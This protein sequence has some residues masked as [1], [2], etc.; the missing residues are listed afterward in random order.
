M[1]NTVITLIVLVALTALG[2]LVY[3]KSN[4]IFPKTATP[5]QSAT[6]AEV[7]ELIKLYQLDEKVSSAYDRFMDYLKKIPSH[8]DETYF[9]KKTAATWAIDFSKTQKVAIT[10]AAVSKIKNDLIQEFN[11]AEVLA[12]IQ[13]K[14][15]AQADFSKAPSAEQKWDA[16]LKSKEL[17]DAMEI[18][19]ERMS[20]SYQYYL[21]EVRKKYGIKDGSFVV[22]K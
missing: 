21:D 9:V 19:R 22:P 16:Y 10:D 7:S 14:K 12:L 11:S 1:K 8:V 20:K 13:K 17:K 2:F 18:P 3:K 4:H 6:V 5:V 15:S